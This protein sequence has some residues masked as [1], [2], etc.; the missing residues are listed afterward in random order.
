MHKQP[1]LM[2]ASQLHDIFKHHI[3]NLSDNLFFSKELAIIHGTP[4]VFRLVMQQQPPFVINDHRLGIIVRGEAD[5]NFNLVDHHLC[6]GTLVYLGPGTIIMP[7]RLSDDLEIYGVGLFSDFAMPFPSGQMPPAFNGQT[8]DF[9][10]RVDEN[11]QQTVLNIIHTLWQMVRQP[12]YSRPSASA[13]VAA[14]IYHYD[15]LYN[16]NTTQHHELSNTQTIFDRFIYLVNRHCTEH[17][18]LS[19]YADRMCLTTRYL[20]TIVRQT[21]GIT[22][23]DWID[24]AL[25]IHAKTQ[26]LHSGKSVARISEELNF[27]NPAFFSKY[28]KRITGVTPLAFARAK[29]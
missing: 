10:L 23:K 25:I 11:A 9:Q 16:S 18:Q 6:A 12:D 26:L 4:D 5:I 22:A 8:R 19:Y 13:L 15:A 3:D 14:L 1:K 24:R 2:G 21:S 7:Q 29:E 28:F 17:H 27:P 20:G